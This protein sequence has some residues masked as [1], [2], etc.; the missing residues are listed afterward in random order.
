MNKS[1]INDG[2]SIQIIDFSNEDKKSLK[3][4]IDFNWKHY[5]NDPNYIPLLDYEYMGFKLI[6]IHGLFEADNLFFKHAK[7]RF[8]LAMRN[9]DIVGR[10]NAF[11]NDHHN[12]H[13]K[14]KVGFFGQFETID[15]SDVSQALIDASANWLKAQGMENI[16]GPQNLPVNE[17]T[18]GVMTE[19]FDS[20][21]VMYYHYNKPYYASLLRNAGFSPVKRVL[22]WEAPVM[23]PME[24]K[25]ERVA[26]KV[27]KRFDLKF[28]TWGERSLDKRKEEM[29]EIYNDAWND[30]YGFVPF[31]KEEFD[32]TI[33]DMQLIIDKGLFLFVYMKGEAVGF[34][35]G[36]PNIVEKL[37]PI[38][39]CH[40]CELLRAVKMLLG[41]NRTKG[42]RL[43]YLG[44]KSQYRSLGLDGVMLWQQKQYSQ[45]KGYEYCD[46]GWVLEDNEVVIRLVEMM[47]GEISKIYTI[48]QK[49]L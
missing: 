43:G 31:T 13:W 23:Q 18:P 45:K 38:P 27:I 48:F 47:G 22:S 36:V 42:F 35:G 10:C 15:D 37:T 39:G 46:I 26:K 44:V 19:G 1:T 49:N 34:F 16:R 3:K 30:N 24:E 8:F 17:A 25:L 2:D 6:G 11:V 4:F 33:D 21:P 20:R 28:E 5:K 40:R 41:K 14:D 29:R 7:M 9:G 32:V 12:K